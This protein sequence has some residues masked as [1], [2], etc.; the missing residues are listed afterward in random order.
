MSY[1]R[2]RHTI[3]GAVEEPHDEESAAEADGALGEEKDAIDDV[4]V[5][6]DREVAIAQSHLSLQ[7][8][9]VG[10]RPAQKGGYKPTGRRRIQSGIDRCQPISSV[11]CYT[12]FV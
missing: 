5:G 1:R 3:D 11:V 4:G 10:R 6:K 12:V 8:Q 2:R 9:Q 7:Q